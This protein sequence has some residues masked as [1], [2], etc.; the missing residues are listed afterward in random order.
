LHAEYGEYKYAR[1]Y[2]KKILDEDA[3]DATALNNMGNIE[4][5]EGKYDKAKEY[6]F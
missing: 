4:F 1:K 6:Y 5:L 2:L 3:L